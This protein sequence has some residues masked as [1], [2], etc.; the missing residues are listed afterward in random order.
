MSDI[1]LPIAWKLPTFK[2]CILENLIILKRIIGEKIRYNEKYLSASRFCEVDVLPG[3]FFCISKKA[4]R[5]VDFFDENTFLYYEENIL[6]AKLKEKKYHN[7]IITEDEYIHN[8]SVSINK[9]IK[10]VRQRLLIASRSRL[11]YC[12][13]YLKIKKWQEMLYNITVAIGTNDYVLLKSIIK[14]MKNK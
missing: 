1:D 7:Y 11:Y 12:K 5:D 6:S 10:S 14:W 2:D 9:S 3:S 13:H 4:I 8:H